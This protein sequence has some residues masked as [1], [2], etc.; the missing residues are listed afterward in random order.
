MIRKL[1]RHCL[2]YVRYDLDGNTF[3]IREG[4]EILLRPSGSDEIRE[5]EGFVD[6][7]EIWNYIC[8][9]G[10][11]GTVSMAFEGPLSFL[12]KILFEPSSDVVG[13]YVSYVP[14]DVAEILRSLAGDDGTTSRSVKTSE[15]RHEI[16]VFKL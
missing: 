7:D 14:P 13:E 10:E 15:I 4:G 16:V 1:L 5:L 2:S 3:E 12:A 8:E 9:G 6:L 11:H